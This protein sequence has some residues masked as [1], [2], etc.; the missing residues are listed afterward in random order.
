MKRK[1]KNFLYSIIITFLYITAYF[2]LGA[3]F[4][5]AKSPYNHSIKGIINNI[6]IQI[7]PI[8]GI[9]LLRTYI[10]LRS[11]N[12]KVIYFTTILLI[13]LEINYKI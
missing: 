4:G 7:I 6:F 9:E 2:L 1:D 11:K 8:I 10:V 12:K 13:L 3:Y 5:F